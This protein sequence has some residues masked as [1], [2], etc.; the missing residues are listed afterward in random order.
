MPDVTDTAY[1]RL[2]AHPSAKDLDEIYTP[3]LFEVVFAEEPTR[4]PATRVGLLLL[5]KTFQRLGYFVPYA[6]VPPSI[7][8]H[9]ARCADCTGVPAGMAAYDASTARD[10][11]MALVRAFVGVTAYGPAA[12]KIVVEASLEAAR[13]HD[14]LADIINVALEELVRQ[15]YE[16]PAFVTLLRIARAARARVN[17]TITRRCVTGWTP[18]RRGM[19]RMRRYVLQ[20]ITAHPRHIP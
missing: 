4:Q 20:G 13:T 17:R 11:R 18:R 7:V 3:N 8:A 1:P 12:R 6:E 2:K 19:A 16:L 5:L 14:D 9:I 15:R 10:R